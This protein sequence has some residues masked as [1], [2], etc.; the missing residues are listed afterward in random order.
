MSK[1]YVIGATGGIGSKVVKELLEKN[2]QV[3][4]LVRNSS[5]AEQLFGQPANLTLVKGDYEKDL[6]GYKSTIAGHDRLF[7]LVHSRY[8]PAIKLNLATIAYAAGVQQVVQVSSASVCGPWRA[9][10][11]ASQHYDSEVGLLGIPNRGKY[12]TLRPNQFFSNHL[13][14]DD[15]TIRAKNVIYGSADPDLGLHWVSPNDIAKVAVTVMT[16]PVE[17]HDDCVYDL[18]SVKYTGNERAAI[19]SKV[20]G[21]EIKYVQIPVEQ[22]YKIFTDVVHM[23]HFVAIGLVSV[24]DFVSPVNKALPILLGRPVEGLD[25]WFEANKEKFL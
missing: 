9:S 2:V 22:R 11:I 18:T 25:A 6:D 21:K 3:T 16:E 15:K 19:I 23:P 24:E 13:F 14:S 5:K 8:M 4:A 17:K 1:V 20:L 7:L 10:F 12:V